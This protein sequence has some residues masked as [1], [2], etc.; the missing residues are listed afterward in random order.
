MNSVSVTRQVIIPVVL[1]VSFLAALLAALTFFFAIGDYH[2]YHH[3]GEL[4]AF[5]TIFERLLPA[6]WLLPLLAIGFGI[7]LARQPDRPA[8]VLAWYCAST[9]IIG[10]L[11]AASTFVAL[12]LMHVRFRQNL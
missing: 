11:W 5:S 8:A 2:H 9:A 1:A 7:V 10:G 3:L 12:H 6:A 4:P